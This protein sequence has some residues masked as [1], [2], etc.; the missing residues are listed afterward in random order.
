M[1]RIA[2]ALDHGSAFA[3]SG[4]SV[5]GRIWACHRNA[6][7]RHRVRD[8]MNPEAMG[9][10]ENVFIV[11]G[12]ARLPCIDHQFDDRILARASQA[13]NGSNRA[14]LAQK[15]ENAGA[16]GGSSRCPRLVNM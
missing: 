9:K 16:F 5:T 4:G 15:M 14:A 6:G 12:G 1:E 2:A 7:D 8:I 11:V 3:T 13:S 10:I